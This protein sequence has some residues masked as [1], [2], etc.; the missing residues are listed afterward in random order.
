MIALNYTG[1]CNFQYFSGLSGYTNRPKEALADIFT[2][3]TPPMAAGPNKPPAFR[4]PYGGIYLFA[5]D[6]D[7]ITADNPYA[8]NL[9]KCIEEEKL[10]AVTE[11]VAKNPAHFGKT[12]VLYVWV[13]DQAACKAWWDKNVLQPYQQKQAA[14]LK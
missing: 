9:M 14:I 7:C 6:S 3:P 4:K 5:Q 1:N 11:I 2:M 10:G 12:G 13:L 8:P